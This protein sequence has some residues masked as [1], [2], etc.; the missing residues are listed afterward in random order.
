MK[1]DLSYINQ[2]TQTAVEH[3]IEHPVLPVAK[4]NEAARSAQ[5][6]IA[7][8]S[9][10][11]E[12]AH[13][14]TIERS[15]AERRIRLEKFREDRASIVEELDKR[16]IMPLAIIPKT[17]WDHIC[18]RSKLLMLHPDEDGDVY[19]SSEILRAFRTR[20]EKIMEFADMG[21]GICAF[22][23]MLIMGIWGTVEHNVSWGDRTLGIL[24]SVAMSFVLAMILHSAIFGEKAN[25]KQIFYR[26][27]LV[28]V[29]LWL[30][31]LR[32]WEAKLQTLFPSGKSISRGEDY[33]MAIRLVLPQPPM[34]VADVLLKA[35]D[36]DLEVAAMGGA[37]MFAEPPESALRRLH[38]D[39][40]AKEREEAAERLRKFQEW[41]KCPIIYLKH[42]SAVAVIAQFGD[43]PIERDVVDEVVN[44]E[45]LL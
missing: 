45:Y 26:A 24:A 9:V 34:D 33:A 30:F 41:L 27:K 43:F 21:V 19:A 16:D 37:I 28:Q 5:F 4:Q 7:G 22:S 17:A 39:L 29:Q 44:S 31:S 1:A 8:I 12:N 38:G 40:V 10:H 6:V 14:Q 3:Q 32:S 11:D 20:A 36:F 25:R 2:A 18:A 13:Q 35:R 15:V 23:T 42:R